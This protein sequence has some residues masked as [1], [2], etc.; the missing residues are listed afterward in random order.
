MIKNISPPANILK[1][2]WERV[3]LLEIVRG[4]WVTLTHLARNLINLPR[5]R[6]SDTYQWPETPK[7]IA[8]VWRGEHRLMLRENGGPRCV[9]CNCCATAC[10]ADCIHITAKDTGSE[11]VE[12]FPLIFDIDVLQCI[13]C[14]MCVEACPC[15]AIRMDTGIHMPP[16][17]HRTQALLRKED[18]MQRGSRTIAVQGGAGPDWRETYRILGDTRAIYDSRQRLNESIKGS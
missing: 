1:H 18:L 12:K 6:V 3:Y 7:P 14:G 15:D 4:L 9:A 2:W 10:P 13:Y 16:V 5:G 11:P 17:E 8:E